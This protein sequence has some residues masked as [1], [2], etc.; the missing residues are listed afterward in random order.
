[1]FRKDELES[2]NRTIN[3]TP[4]SIKN[5]ELKLQFF[6]WRNLH[7]DAEYYGRNYP[8]Y[9]PLCFTWHYALFHL[10]WQ[11]LQNKYR[12]T[13]G[14]RTNSSYQ[15]QKQ[16][17][18]DC[19]HRLTWLDSLLVK[20]LLG[21]RQTSNEQL[22]THI[23]EQE[24]IENLTCMKYTD[25]RY[26]M[27][28]DIHTCYLTYKSLSTLQTYTNTFFDFTEKVKNLLNLFDLE[29]YVGESKTS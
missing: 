5:L 16:D 13:G 6:Q 17:R 11:Y 14:V 19:K 10:I 27:C 22:P 21:L 18:Y 28:V 26:L 15:I 7:M 2:R 3:N 9:R 24:S 12:F 1:M 8:E 20:R 23:P 4:I 29:K 25:V